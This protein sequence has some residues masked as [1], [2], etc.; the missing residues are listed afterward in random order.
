MSDTGVT[1]AGT[2]EQCL[3]SMKLYENSGADE[4]ML[5]VQNETVPHEVSCETIRKLGESVIPHF[6]R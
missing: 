6:H 2:P 4:L 5:L 1:V 3:E